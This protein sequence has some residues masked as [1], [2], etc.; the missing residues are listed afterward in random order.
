MLKLWSYPFQTEHTCFSHQYFRCCMFSVM[1][2]SVH[3]IGLW[4]WMGE[5]SYL[6]LWF[7]LLG[8][9]Y[10]QIKALREFLLIFFKVSHEQWTLNLLLNTSRKY[11]EIWKQIIWIKIPHIPL[12]QESKR[13]CYEI[14]QLIMGTTVSKAWRIIAIG[15]DSRV[16][17]LLVR[18]QVL[19]FWFHWILYI[20]LERE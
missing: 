15:R 16:R 12:L 17:A 1:Y 10:F 5:T 13:I 14:S 4:A 7:P 11:L 8:E 6:H 2:I 20:A 3:Y 19:A 9:Y 18:K